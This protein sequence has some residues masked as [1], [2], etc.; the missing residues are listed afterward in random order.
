VAEGE[1]AKGEIAFASEAALA[2]SGEIRRGVVFG[3]VDDAEIF[4]AAYL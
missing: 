2:E 1:F 3:A 4:V